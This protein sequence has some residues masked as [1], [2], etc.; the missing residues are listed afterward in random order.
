MK[1]VV[2]DEVLWKALNTL[3]L[4]RS[5]P[6][7]ERQYTSL[8]FQLANGSPVTLPKQTTSEFSDNPATREFLELVRCSRILDIE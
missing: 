6:E 5:N 4:V 1:A 8:V 3:V 2:T 7:I